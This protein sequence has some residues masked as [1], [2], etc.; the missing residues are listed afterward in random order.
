MSAGRNIHLDISFNHLEYS[1]FLG[2]LCHQG[3]AALL[4]LI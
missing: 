3:M 2:L 1:P 4:R